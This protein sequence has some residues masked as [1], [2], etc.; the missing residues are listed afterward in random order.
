MAVFS[1]DRLLLLT[2]FLIPFSYPL[3]KIAPNLGF[4]LQLPTE[5]MIILLMVVFL[6]KVMLE[7]E[8]D[9]AVLKHPVTIAIFIYL[10]WMFITCI[11]STMPLVSFKYFI[12]RVWFIAVFYFLASQFF[13]SKKNIRS[14]Y[15]TYTVAFVVIMIMTIYKMWVRGFMDPYVAQFSTRPFFNDHTSYGAIVAMILPFI[16]CFL[17][18]KKYSLPLKIL[19][20]L[21]LVIAAIALVLSYT[22]AA[23]ISA[24]IAL[25]VWLMMV[26][27]IKFIYIIFLFSF[28]LGA[29]YLN[30]EQIVISMEKNQQDSSKDLQKHLK[31]V[32]NIRS[33][34]SNMERINRWKCAIKMFSE[35]PVFGWGPGT[36]MFKYAPFQVSYDRTEISTNRGNWGNA[37]SEY[38]GPL[39]ESGLFGSL[40]FTAIVVLVFTT[41]FSCY[42]KLKGKKSTQLLI[43]GATLGLVTYCSHGVLNNYLDTDKASA[44]F[45]GFVG[46]IVAIDL[47][48]SEGKEQTEFE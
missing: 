2:L 13:K 34:A 12:S 37:H 6:L 4:N 23:W 44:L 21:V 45:W 30:R 40:T 3:E 24:G 5:I 7:K 15:W 18:Y 32:Y 16:V 31:S 29:L 41:A 1:I 19:I 17:F 33:D 47:Y 38:L 48:H 46:M 35:K 14:Y 9:K 39:A 27:R 43:L 22:R 20:A 42:R 10:A 8:F 25:F 26:W 36:Y 28:I 11:T